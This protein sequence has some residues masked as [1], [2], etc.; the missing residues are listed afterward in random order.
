MLVDAFRYPL[1]G[2]DART[3]WPVLATFG[4]GSA[5][6]SRFAVGLHPTSLSLVLALL[7]AVQSVAGLLALAVT[8]YASLI[9]ARPV[10]SGYRRVVR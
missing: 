3:V 8:V 4:L 1:R 10:G 7:A 9:A 2:V 6:L 5:L